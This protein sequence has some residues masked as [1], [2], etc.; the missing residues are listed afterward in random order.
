MPFLGKPVNQD[1]GDFKGLNEK[2]IKIEPD[3]GSK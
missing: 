2:P 3:K 1:Y